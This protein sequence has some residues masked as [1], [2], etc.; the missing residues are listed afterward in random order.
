MTQKTCLVE[1]KFFPGG[2]LLELMLAFLYI[3][4]V[5]K[6]LALEKL[7]WFGISLAGKGCY[8]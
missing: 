8:L 1:A 3:S 4:G 2:I 6:F 5:L 7:W